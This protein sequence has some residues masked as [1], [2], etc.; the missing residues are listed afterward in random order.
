MPVRVG[1]GPISMNRWK[2]KS[3]KSDLKS[4]S[5]APRSELVNE[6]LDEDDI[7][8]SADAQLFKT[9]SRRRDDVCS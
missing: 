9:L 5:I 8:C 2:A 4:Q 7:R 3:L 6:Q 1:E